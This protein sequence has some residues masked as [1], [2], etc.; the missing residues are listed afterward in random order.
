MWRNIE[1]HILH[2]KEVFPEH[3]DFYKRLKEEIPWHKV[4][5]RHGTLP[6]LCC[7]GVQKFEVGAIIAK[8]LE[9]FCLQNLKCEVKIN[10]VF[11]NYYRN[12][13]D[14]LPH[15]RDNYT[16]KDGTKL[17]VISISFGATRIFEF[18]SDNVTAFRQPLNSGDILFFD[19]FMN[20]NYTHGINKL[21]HVEGR[22]NLTCF[23]SYPKLLPYGMKPEGIIMS[24]SA[25]EIILGTLRSECKYDDVDESEALAMALQNSDMDESEALAIALQ[26]L[27]KDKQPHVDESEALAIALQKLEWGDQW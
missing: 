6:R 7:H 9:V 12:G 18:K 11:G 1:P 10:D 16:S 20:E 21:A 4:P 19:P 26:K 17:H 2:L 24:P 8:W 22:I 23:V 25:D 3:L 13:N 27:D 5:W 15:H 14:H